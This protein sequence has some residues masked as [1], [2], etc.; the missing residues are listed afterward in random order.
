MGV[1]CTSCHEPHDFSQVYM[2]VSNN[3]SKLCLSCHIK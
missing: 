1:G 3:G 2:R